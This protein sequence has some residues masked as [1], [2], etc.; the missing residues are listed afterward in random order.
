MAKARSK[1]RKTSARPLESN[2][3]PLS[4]LCPGEQGVVVGMDGGRNVLCRMT[5]LGFTPGVEVAVVQ[6]H[7]WGPLIARVRA[8]CVALGRGEASRIYVERR[9]G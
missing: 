9:G 2:G 7:G 3:V 6:N 8:S 1:E 5:S 4:S